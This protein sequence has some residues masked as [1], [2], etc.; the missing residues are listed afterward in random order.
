MSFDLNVKLLFSSLP[1]AASAPS[2]PHL[3][4]DSN[5]E[6]E[7]LAADGR[8]EKS[9]FKFRSEDT[10]GFRLSNG[11]RKAIPDL[12]ACGAEATGREDRFGAW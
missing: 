10:D 9:S 5:I 8:L 7:A 3:R 6:S 1:S 12:R 11:I 4:F 2:P